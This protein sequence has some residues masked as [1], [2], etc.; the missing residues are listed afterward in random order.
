MQIFCQNISVKVERLCN[1]VHHH[2]EDSASMITGRLNGIGG[3]DSQGSIMI[4]NQHP[5]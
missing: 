1:I 2:A 3:G 4:I 5:Q